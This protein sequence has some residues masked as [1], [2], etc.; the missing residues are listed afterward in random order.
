VKVLYD[1]SV[2]IAAILVEHSNHAAALSK[3]E[4]ATSG[5]VQGYLSTHSLAELYSVMTRL[6]PPLRVTPEEAVA[7]LTDLTEY[8]EPITLVA[9]DYQRA[10]ALMAQLNLPGGGIFDAVIAQAALKASVDCLMT[11][12]AKDFV[13]L[14]QEISA[15]VQVPE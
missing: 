13:R 12:N 3:L 4:L 5:E 14:G 11:F 2:L 8:I 15:L 1:T 9:A 10:I 7:I 6:P